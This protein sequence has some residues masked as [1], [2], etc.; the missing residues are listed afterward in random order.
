L[1][2]VAAFFAGV[3]DS[4][5]GGG[6]LIQ[7]PA[8]FAGYPATAPQELLGTNKLGSICGTASAVNRYA[9]FTHIPWK[10]LLPAVAV[11]FF[12]ALAGATIVNMV[13]PRALRPLVPIMLCVVLGYVLLHPNLG[14]VHAPRPLSK[15]RGLAA[16]A[17]VLGI[18]VYDGFFGPGTGSFLMLLFVRVHGFDFL[19][20][21]AAARLVNVATNAGALVSFAAHSQVRYTLGLALGL[22][23]AAGS[24]TG[25]RMAR[26]HGA[27]FVRR[28]F[29]AVVLALI[30]RTAWNALR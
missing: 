19:H 26:R 25:T 7:L 9:R 27:R 4:M 20:A 15:R 22:C 18:G 6:G 28:V 23:N 30:A 2:L 24:I 13:S 29:V 16:L 1:V 3:V 14:T 17:G 12:A 5:V 10:A 21:S 11:A 8:L